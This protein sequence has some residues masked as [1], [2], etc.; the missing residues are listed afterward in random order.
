MLKLLKYLFI[1]TLFTIAT[2]F[3]TQNKGDITI[4]WMGYR[5]Y[6]EVTFVVLFSALIAIFASL[7]FSFFKILLLPIT[8]R[9]NKSLLVL[10]KLISQELVNKQNTC[11]ILADF[12]AG[13]ISYHEIVVLFRVLKD[14]KNDKAINPRLL[15][16]IQYMERKV[17]KNISIIA[18]EILLK[19]L[20]VQKENS[21][22]IESTGRK[23]LMNKKVSIN[24][25]T[26]FANYL[27]KNPNKGLL[28]L[29]IN[30][31]EQ[32]FNET[33]NPSEKSKAVYSLTVTT[34][35]KLLQETDIKK[36][37]T[38]ANISLAYANKEQVFEAFMERFADVKQD[39]NYIKMLDT[40]IETIFSVN[41]INTWYKNYE[42]QPYK[43]TIAKCEKLALSD[44]QKLLLKAYISLKQNKGFESDNYLSKFPEKEK[45]EIYRSIAVEIFKRKDLPHKALE[46]YES[47]TN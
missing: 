35:I 40:Y 42:E 46:V 13:K 33:K 27:I 47:I 22:L 43:K 15:R 1:V 12:Y 36:A 44:N 10:K 18:S 26:D 8:R 19:R 29:C 41:S 5:I 21:K 37:T 4:D 3:L 11:F 23:G 24:L 30:K 14:L 6:T 45:N 2:I 16:S 39:K 34:Y 9:S 32:Y 38:S 31:F 20:I 17:K 28:S 7:V 25:V